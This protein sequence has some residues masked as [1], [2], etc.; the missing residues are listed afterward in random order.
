[1]NLLAWAQDAG[2]D[3]GILSRLLGIDRI[4]P[5]QGSISLTWH[6][7]IPLW[8]VVLVVIPAI[9]GLVWLI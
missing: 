9:A 8:V 1:M 2:S 7:E 3:E 4:D 5:D 6:H